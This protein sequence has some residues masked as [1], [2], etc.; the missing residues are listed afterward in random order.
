MNKILGHPSWDIQL[1]DPVFRLAFRFCLFVLSRQGW[2]FYI[3]LAFIKL[4]KKMDFVHS[5]SHK[6]LGEGAELIQF[7]DH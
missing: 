7:I 2:L 3:W 5:G 6:V 4:Q 1:F